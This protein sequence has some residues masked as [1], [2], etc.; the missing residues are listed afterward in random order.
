M[1]KVQRVRGLPAEGEATQPRWRGRACLV[2]WDLALAVT[3]ALMGLAV[4]FDGQ[5]P[6]GAAPEASFS[7]NPPAASLF[8]G[9]PELT[10][11]EEVS[12]VPSDRGVGA[13]AIAF[14]YNGGLIQVTVEQGPF[15]SSTG[16][17]TFCSTVNGH[18]YVEFYCGS[19]GLEPGASGSG[20]LAY[21]RVRPHPELSLRPTL[22]NG[23]VAL[24]DD[25]EDKAALTDVLG[26]P[27]ELGQAGDATIIVR[28][29]EGDLNL[30]CTVNVIDEQM[31]SFR[32]Q[33][34]FGVFPY[35]EFYDLEPARQP[36]G[37][38]DIKDVQFVYG[39]DGRICEG[40]TPTPTLTPTATRSPT[41][42]PPT[43]TPSPTGT[44]PTATPS[45]TGTPPTATRSPTGTPPT[46]TRSPT[47]T[48]PTATPS[49]TGTPPTATPSP[50][51]T[52]LTATPTPIAT[53]VTATPTA[54]GGVV[55][56]STAAPSATPAVASPTMAVTAVASPSGGVG[57]A[58]ITPH[59][60][61]RRLP[62][63]G[64]GT[65]SGQ[66]RSLVV[67]AVVLIIVGAV[68][69]ALVAFRRRRAEDQEGASR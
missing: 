56:T 7:K 3:L 23:V 17:H 30:D 33:S 64:G 42:T 4:G 15:L 29:L 10:I 27:I 40:P 22:N 34:S 20:V 8:L 39:R 43:A 54:I 49:P 38:I 2:F 24:L 67:A 16:R 61:A 65:D 14:F 41:G 58:E 53:F 5:Q 59:P 25:Q 11:A 50:T 60:A 19:T 31:I 46:A 12:S 32:F 6:A 51:G 26:S 13:F 9:G 21:I 62:P 63:A 68:L 44:P 37:D 35:H 48:P 28:A 57:P 66:P 18:N 47:G 52:P 45:P 69:V 1:R 55:P 36:D